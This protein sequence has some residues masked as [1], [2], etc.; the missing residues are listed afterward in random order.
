MYLTRLHVRYDAEN[1]PEDLVFQETGDRSNF[2][3]LYVLHHP[4]QGGSSCT[5]AEDYFRSLAHRRDGEAQNLAH[6]TG[7]DVSEIRKKMQIGPVA[8]TSPINETW[9]EKIWKNRM[10]EA[11]LQSPKF[12]W[13]KTRGPTLLNPWDSPPVS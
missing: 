13:E 12:T 11:L 1:F 9:W 4:W 3:G 10:R 5:A 6:L 8:V 2:Q 7:W